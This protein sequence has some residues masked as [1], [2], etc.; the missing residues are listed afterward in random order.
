M[1]YIVSG[2]S[3]LT[4][5][6]DIGAIVTITP[7]DADTG[8]PG[9]QVDL[10]AGAETAIMVR[11]MP[12]DPAAQ[13]KTYTANVY[14]KNVPGSESDDATLSSLM[15][16]GGVLTP[17]FASGTMEY[18]AAAAHST[19][20]TTVTAIA[21][22]IG[23][24]SSIMIGTGTGAAYYARVKMPT[25]HGWTGHQVDLADWREHHH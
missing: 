15:L 14:R 1:W 7:T 17:A 9:H 3:R 19:E 13:S 24:Q 23:A 12:E 10:T 20:M 21:N 11:V 25:G 5:T 4:L 22:H 16:S 6:A 8:E 2:R 18:E